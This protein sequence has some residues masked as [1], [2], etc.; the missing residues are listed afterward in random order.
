[1][2]VRELRKRHGLTL[3][4]VA[5][6]TGYCVGHLS[7]VERGVVDSPY[8]VRNIRKYFGEHLPPDEDVYLNLDLLV[9]LAERT[10]EADRDSVDELVMLYQ[11]IVRDYETMVR[12]EDYAL[13]QW[14]ADQ[15]HRLERIFVYYIHHQRVTITQAQCIAPEVV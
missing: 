4:E 7:N 6:A 10:T 14:L 9:A 5:D 1:M 13:A 12:V 3:Q 8:A 15:Y 11:Q 2:T